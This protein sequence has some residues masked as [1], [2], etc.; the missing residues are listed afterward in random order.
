MSPKLQ[1]TV[2]VAVHSPWA[3]CQ[4]LGHSQ[5]GGIFQRLTDISVLE[6]AVAFLGF[7]DIVYPQGFRKRTLAYL[8]VRKQGTKKT[9]EP[10]PQFRNKRAAQTGKLPVPK[11]EIDTKIL[12]VYP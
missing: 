8:S 4:C 9:G 12:S 7:P 3:A 1:T 5:P 11:L 10:A 2:S 6:L